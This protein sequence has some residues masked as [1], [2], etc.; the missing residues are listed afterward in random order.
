MQKFYRLSAVILILSLVLVA[1]PPAQ[2]YEI[3]AAVSGRNYIVEGSFA[4]TSTGEVFYRQPLSWTLLGTV[5]GA[6]A[7]SGFD[8]ENTSNRDIWLITLESGLVYRRQ[9]TEVGIGPAVFLSVP[10]SGAPIRSFTITLDAG[11]FIAMTLVQEDGTICAGASPMVPPPG[12]VAVT[13]T[14]WGA[15]KDKFKGD[16]PAVTSARDEQTDQ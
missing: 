3:I 14:T 6:F 16:E 15:V 4:L 10:C 11:N 9:V 7:F 12:T 2:A 13:E 8:F 1:A 5:P